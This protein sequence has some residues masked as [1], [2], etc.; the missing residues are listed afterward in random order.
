[1]FFKAYMNNIHYRLLLHANQVMMKYFS[2][3][4]IQY[5]WRS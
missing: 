1:M 2:A 5:W 3:I 4:L